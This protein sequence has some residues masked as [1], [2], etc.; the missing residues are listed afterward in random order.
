MQI[1]LNQ[2]HIEAA[3]KDYMT[4]AGMTFEVESIDFTAGRG[5]TGLTASVE[6]EDPF[7]HMLPDQNND[8]PV[9]EKEAKPSTAKAPKGKDEPVKEKVDEP[10]AVETGP[11]PFAKASQEFAKEDEETAP[12]EKDEAVAADN[13]EQV[14]D[15][16][17]LFS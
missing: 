9:E 1:T 6:M 10:K 2:Q 13:E 17:S 15:K 7:S 3:I 12:F 16:K 14:K 5:K 11:S 4:K 8:A